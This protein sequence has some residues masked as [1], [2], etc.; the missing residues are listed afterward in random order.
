VLAAASAGTL[1]ANTAAVMTAT[2]ATSVTVRC[3][4]CIVATSSMMV[5]S[6]PGTQRVSLHERQADYEGAQRIVRDPLDSAEPDYRA[7]A[8]PVAVG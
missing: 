1:T 2:L 3:L 7:P 8:T 4:L 6:L 5:A